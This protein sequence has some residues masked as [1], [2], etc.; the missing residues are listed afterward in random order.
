VSAPNVSFRLLSGATPPYGK[1]AG[2]CVEIVFAGIRLC[3]RLKYT[4]QITNYWVKP[5]LLSGRPAP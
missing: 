3:D 2:A 1:P 5:R 4:F